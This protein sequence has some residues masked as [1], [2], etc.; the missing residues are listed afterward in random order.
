MP[1]TGQTSHGQPGVTPLVSLV[2]VFV[3]KKFEVEDEDEDE[4]VV[5]KEIRTHGGEYD[6]YMTYIELIGCCT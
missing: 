1:G 2:S 3:D 6:L 4:K 5:P